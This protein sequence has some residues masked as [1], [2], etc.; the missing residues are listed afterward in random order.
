MKIMTPK[1][2]E[3]EAV[4]FFSAHLSK[5]PKIG[6]LQY[7]IDAQNFIMKTMSQMELRPKRSLAKKGK[8]A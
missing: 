8:N 7:A 1:E 2:W 3:A 6:L 4:D 5:L